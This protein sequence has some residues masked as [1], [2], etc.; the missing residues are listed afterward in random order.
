M[1][2]FCWLIWMT[3]CLAQLTLQ[4]KLQESLEQALN[5]HSS[6]QV[7]AFPNNSLYNQTEIS[8]LLENVKISVNSHD[9]K[10]VESLC[11]QTLSMN[12]HIE[13]S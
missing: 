6:T 13:Q 11:I 10:Y 5:H 12:T 8:Q 1:W 9:S 7:F 3:I 2:C 4:Q